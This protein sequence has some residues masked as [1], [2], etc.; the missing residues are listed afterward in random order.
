MTGGKM[1]KLDLPAPANALFRNVYGVLHD[2]IRPVSP[3]G[4]LGRLGG[5]TTLAARWGH[6]RSTD[7]DLTV[8]VGTG[9]G[10]YDPM[11]DSRLVD[12]MSAMG[13]THVELRLRSFTFTFPNGKLDLVEMDPQL[14]VGHAEAEVDGVS[15]EVYSNAQ[16]LCGKL[17]G[18]GNMLPERDIFDLAVASELD[19]TALTAAVNHLDDDFRREVVHGLRAQVDQYPSTAATVLDPS[20][21]RWQPLLTNAPA[22][23]ARAIETVAYA[24]VVVGY[25]ERGIVLRLGSA[26]GST[27]TLSFSAGDEFAEAVAK[28]GLAPCFLNVLG[29]FDAL[30]G[31]VDQQLQAWRLSGQPA[32]RF[33]PPY[34]SAPSWQRSR[35]P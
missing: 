30:A 10:R 19:P 12:R 6:R 23:A 9:L 11:R 21:A 24:S 7:I 31:H 15:I 26:S 5:G 13:A 1:E 29:T 17:E 22:L 18:R 4:T 27:R 3:G 25:D 8:P 33:D 35:D 32:S 2:L 16:I 20:D 14:P 34:R 28:L